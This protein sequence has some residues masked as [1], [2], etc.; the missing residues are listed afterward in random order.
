MVRTAVG[1]RYCACKKEIGGQFPKF[2]LHLTQSSHVL[3]GH[4]IRTTQRDKIEGLEVRFLEFAFGD[5]HSKVKVCAVHDVVDCFLKC[6]FKGYAV[7]VRWC[8]RYT[9][10]TSSSLV[11]G[12]HTCALNHGIDREPPMQKASVSHY[13][14]YITQSPQRRI[15]AIAVYIPFLAAKP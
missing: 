15:A 6:C 1:A 11:D 10:G 14:D 3:D 9:Y 2:C 13:N 7:Q 8:F 12:A 5:R 4:V